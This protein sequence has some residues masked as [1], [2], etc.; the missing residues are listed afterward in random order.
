V[1]TRRVSQEAYCPFTGIN[2]T[3]EWQAFIHPRLISDEFPCFYGQIKENVGN[4]GLKI[5]KKWV[6]VTGRMYQMFFLFG[7]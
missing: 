3:D 7:F 6:A 2:L 5:V 1:L 4:D